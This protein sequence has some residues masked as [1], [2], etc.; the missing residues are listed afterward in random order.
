MKSGRTDANLETEPRLERVKIGVL[1]NPLIE[2][3]PK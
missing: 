2:A 1:S 3:R